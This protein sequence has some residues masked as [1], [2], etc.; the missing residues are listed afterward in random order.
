CQLGQR[1]EEVHLQP[2]QFVQALQG[3]ESLL[4]GVAVVADDTADGEPVALLYV[5]LVVLLVPAAA[6]EADAVLAAPTLQAVVDE[7]RAV[8]RVQLAQS[9]GHRH[10]GAVERSP[11]PGGAEPP[12]WP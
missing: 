5:G 8:V 2:L 7:L 9:E 10:G 6:A 1:P 3:L 12:G 4:R 11:Y